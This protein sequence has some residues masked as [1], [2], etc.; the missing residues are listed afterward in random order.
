MKQNHFLATMKTCLLL[1][2]GVLLASC[3]D[4]YDGNDTFISDVQN[5]TLESPNEADVTLTPSSDGT[6]LTIQWPVVF[7]AGGYEFKLLNANDETTP[8]VNEIIDGC[9]VTVG[10]E[11]DMNYKILIRTLGNE[12]LNNKE[13]VNPT[14]MA[15]STFTETYK[16][17][18][19]CDLYQYFQENPIPDT[20]TGELNFDLEGNGQYTVSQPLDFKYHKVVL[21]STD[22]NHHAIITIAE[23]A[24][25][26]VSND[27]TLKYVDVDASATLKPVMEA[28]NYDVAPDDILPKPGNYYLIDFVRI[29]NCSIKGVVGSLFYDNNKAYAVVN[30]LIKNTIIQA[31][32]ATERIKNE[33][34]ISFQGGGVKDFS[35]S[36]STVY[37][38]GEGNSKY[39][40]RYNNS[41][42]VDRLG[43][44]T[45]ERTTMTYTNNTFYKMASGNWANY[46]GIANYS[47]YDI[48]NNIWYS[49]G[50][51]ATARRIMGN[52]RLGNG[53]SAT[54]V[55]NTYWNENGQVDQGNYDTGVVLTT[56]PGFVDAANANF[57]PTGS[58]QLEKGTGDPRW[59]NTGE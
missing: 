5:A 11:E 22:K 10:I 33:S 23:D 51:G 56:D 24:N 40:L 6:E 53:S 16:E 57:T 12:S 38:T 17:I 18:S 36:Y 4:T 50:D 46:S 30:F 48:Q 35:I 25:F 2:A 54:W 3:A 49:C 27:F 31:N 34:F 47:T 29:M 19:P 8:L 28:Y 39:F 7:G 21:R 59:L 43:Y 41:I 52:G 13:A 20:E 45:T 1:T 15:Y 37:Q 14:T 32:T 42:R 26:I 58:E 44:A 9:K 55:Y